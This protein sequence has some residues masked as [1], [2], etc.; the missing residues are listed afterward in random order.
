MRSTPLPLAAVVVAAVAAA[1]AATA[2]DDSVLARGLAGWLQLAP[3]TLGAILA[4]CR[5]MQLLLEHQEWPACN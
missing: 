3:W 2:A 4:A 1:A 5:A